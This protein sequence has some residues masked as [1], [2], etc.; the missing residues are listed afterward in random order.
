[1][2]QGGCHIQE[3]GASLAPAMAWCVCSCMVMGGVQPIHNKYS[4][5]SEGGI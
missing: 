2:G 1:M 4:N 5:S 3:D